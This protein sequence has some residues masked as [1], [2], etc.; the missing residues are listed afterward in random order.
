M[1]LESAVKSGRYRWAVL[2]TVVAS[3]TIGIL[4]SFGLPPLAPFIRAD[5]G[6]SREQVGLLTSV[7]F[8]G[9]AVM[10]IPAGSLADRIGVRKVLVGAQLALTVF[11]VIL[12]WAGS[13]T[14][15]LAG[16]FLA[17]LCFGALSPSGAKAIM[18]WFPIRLRATGMGIK[19]MG[20][21]LG[22]VIT[23][24]TLPS[25]AIWIGWRNS[26]SLAATLA[27]F[28]AVF[29]FFVCR[30]RPSRPVD[31][32]VSAGQRV[33]LR[34]LLSNPNL[35]LLIGVGFCLAAVQLS[36]VTYLALYLHESL[37]LSAVVAGAFLAQSQLSS[38]VGRVIFGVLSDRLF[39]GQ[40]LPLLVVLALSSVIFAVCTAF[41]DTATPAWTISLLVV[42]FGASG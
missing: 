35:W 27:F 2:G 3:Q 22:G 33:D 42:L 30:D 15:I 40:R 4:A 37:L 17:G 11:V 32:H 16:V 28:S 10:S 13:Y 14:E 7:Y 21:S 29:A 8:A 18:E 24:A 39:R 38:V 19:Q 36:W 41:L 31:R 5:L 6:L 25:L 34:T 1:L 23:A 12:A 20:N 9:S 26:L